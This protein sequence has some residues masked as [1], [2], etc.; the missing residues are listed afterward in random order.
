M[1]AV[2]KDSSVCV[3]VCVFVCVCV[4]ACA[5]ARACVCKICNS[6]TQVEMKKKRFWEDIDPITS[7][8]ASDEIEFD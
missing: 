7:I 5:C 8:A 6:P 1:E 4:C 3:C 2:H